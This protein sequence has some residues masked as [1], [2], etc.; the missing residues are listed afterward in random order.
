MKAT[1]ARWGGKWGD[2]K[3]I[4]RDGWQG[5]MDGR[6]GRKGRDGEE[7]ESKDSCQKML[8]GIVV[9]IN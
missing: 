6:E 3:W 5:G 7:T 1:A 8:G 9:V 2:G 4:G